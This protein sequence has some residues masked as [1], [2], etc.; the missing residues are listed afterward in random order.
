[1]IFLDPNYIPPSESAMVEEDEDGEDL[2]VP[3]DELLDDMA[4]DDPDADPDEEG[5]AIED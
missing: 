5:I 4:L 2:E 3:I 1:L